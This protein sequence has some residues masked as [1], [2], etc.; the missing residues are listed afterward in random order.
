[1]V[2]LA[3]PQDMK[4]LLRKLI[5]SK[6]PYY[7]SIDTLPAWNYEKTLDTHDPRFLL[8]NIDYE[9][10]PEMFGID[11]DRLSIVMTEVHLQASQYEI[12][13]VK[14]NAI[15][16]DMIKKMEV[17]RCEYDYVRA[18]ITYLYMKG[19]DNYMIEQLRSMGHV[20]KDVDIK[21]QLTSIHNRNENLMIKIN[22][23]DREIKAITNTSTK[24]AEAD[25]V[26][27]LIEQHQK[28]EIDLR[29]ITTKKWL[30]LKH[31]LSEH[32]DK[33]QANKQRNGK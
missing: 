24:K 3:N 14:R 23:L 27:I 22:Q 11:M 2:K 16:F 25:E 31:K 4:T 30:I 8:K 15:V 5:A 28:R 29:K 18:I 10:L 17:L 20:I 32:I 12:D 26:Q 7:R 6:L 19:H 33:L 21:E 9:D 13:T 1:M